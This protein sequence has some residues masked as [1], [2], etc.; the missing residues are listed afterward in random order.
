VKFSEPMDASTIAGTTNIK[1]APTANLASPVAATVTYDASTNS[2]I[3]TPTAP[4]ASGTSYTVT[5]TTGVKDVAGNQLAAQST[6]KFTTIADTIAPTVI[7]T[8]PKNDTTVAA[9]ATITVTFSEDMNPTSVITSTSV[10]KTSDSSPVAGI[11][12]Y[13]AA[14]MTAIFTPTVPLANG[15]GYTVTVTTGAKD[16]AGNGL[17]GNFTFSFTTSP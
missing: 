16:L 14:T 2:A 8:S 3:L 9:P 1:L 17:T 6:S 12:S 4:L 13:N 11:V 7:S 10:K 5:V 15:T